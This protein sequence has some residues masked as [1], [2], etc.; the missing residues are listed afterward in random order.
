MILQHSSKLL[1]LLAVWG[2]LL[3]ISLANRSDY[4]SHWNSLRYHETKICSPFSNN[5][6]WLPAFQLSTEKPQKDRD[7][8]FNLILILGV[9]T[10]VAT[11]EV[12]KIWRTKR[13]S[14]ILYLFIFCGMIVASVLEWQGIST[15]EMV[16]TLTLICMPIVGHL[17][18][19]PITTATVIMG[20]SVIVIG[21]CTRRSDSPHVTITAD[22]KNTQPSANG[23]LAGQEREEMLS[24]SVDSPTQTNG[25]QPGHQLSSTIIA[26][27]YSLPKHLFRAPYRAFKY[28]FRP[29][30]S[31]ESI[32]E[33]AKHWHQVLSTNIDSEDRPQVYSIL[34]A[35]DKMQSNLSQRQN[36]RKAKLL[37]ATAGD[38]TVNAIV[39]LDQELLDFV[40]EDL[41]SLGIE[42]ELQEAEQEDWASNAIAFEAKVFLTKV[43]N[44]FF[45]QLPE[46]TTP[47]QAEK[48]R[49]TLTDYIKDQ[50]IQR[51]PLY[52]HEVDRQKIK[53][54][55]DLDEYFHH[56]K[57]LGRYWKSDYV[58]QEI[59]QETLLRTKIPEL[60][61]LLNLRQ[62]TWW[63]QDQRQK[64]IE[65][66]NCPNCNLTVKPGHTC[67]VSASDK[68][69]YKKGI[70]VRDLVYIKGQQG[71]ITQKKGT[72]PDIETMEKLS[73]KAREQATKSPHILPPIAKPHKQ[74]QDTVMMTPVSSTSFVP[75]STVLQPLSEGKMETNKRVK[76]TEAGQKEIERAIE[77]ET[78]RELEVQE[79]TQEEGPTIVIIDK[80]ASA[81]V[82]LLQVA[83]ETQK[84]QL[85][86]ALKT[87]QVNSV[88]IQ[89]DF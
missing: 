84:H 59:S 50:K 63:E 13:P 30:I 71:Q 52:L 39:S 80:E 3:H 85:C 64:G 75:S 26:A 12:V 11:I 31:T 15:E 46:G 25:G 74:H 6:V 47:E 68:V 17:A 41:E 89:Q 8:L 73:N 70:A 1:L 33:A 83:T 45:S 87:G 49:K 72:I 77:E 10:T 51:N 54:Y 53:T 65:L 20:C 67:L 42:C 16:R 79:D 4:L 24:D 66:T 60:K 22:K 88:E 9:L 48:W 55:L 34:Q 76:V 78:I 5:S 43:A 81:K 38:T 21:V 86:K 27:L 56:R 32:L 23:N 58:K 7:A 40:G 18:R 57:Y 2:L 61:K 82:M 44:D 28:C 19:K 36:K 29:T 14:Y 69:H 62:K 37:T 35:I